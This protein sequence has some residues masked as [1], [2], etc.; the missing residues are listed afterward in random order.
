MVHPDTV[1]HNSY[2]TT[3]Y[4]DLTGVDGTPMP[5]VLDLSDDCPA[6]RAGARLDVV[7]DPDGAAVTWL[8]GV[9][10]GVSDLIG[11]GIGL[12]V[13][14]VCTMTYAAGA[15]RV[16]TPRRRSSA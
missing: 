12:A 6:L 13:L 15:D 5:R 2:P 1:H 11:A 4:Y 10:P 8:P 7:A 16:W 3:G 14:L 9:V